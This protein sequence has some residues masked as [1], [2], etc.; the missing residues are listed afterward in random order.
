MDENRWMNVTVQMDE[1]NEES[2]S[3]SDGHTVHYAA[4]D[5][6]DSEASE[7]FLVGDPTAT[8]KGA[9]EASTPTDDG[10]GVMRTKGG[11]A[12]DGDE[13]GGM[14]A[15]TTKG[16]PPNLPGIEKER[17]WS[18]AM[19]V[20][21]QDVMSKA[22]P[23]KSRLGYEA[24]VAML[25]PKDGPKDHPSVQ[26]RWNDWL[27]RQL[28]VTPTATPGQGTDVQKRA[29][30]QCAKS[31][32]VDEE[33]VDDRAV[34]NAEPD[35]PLEVCILQTCGV[36]L[37]GVWRVTKDPPT[38]TVEQWMAHTGATKAEEVSM[39]EMCFQQVQRMMAKTKTRSKEWKEMRGRLGEAKAAIKRLN[40]KAKEELI[41][42]RKARY[43]S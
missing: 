14:A 4:S 32:I 8:T 5:E 9:D 34:R 1:Q 33:K 11:P 37:N 12:D 27:D 23:E 10:N 41:A 6:K 20:R 39:K 38:C 42:Q 25:F 18:A 28:N 21:A 43:R 35:M 13:D 2:T 22:L 29:K 17:A 7:S 16:G 26:R 40:K 24:T 31:Q 19:L 15:S 30:S 36:M 3:S